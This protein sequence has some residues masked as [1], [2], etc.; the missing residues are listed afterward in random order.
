[1]DQTLH[2]GKTDRKRGRTPGE[3]AFDRCFLPVAALFV[4]HITTFLTAWGLYPHPYKLASIPVSSWELWTS[5]SIGVLLAVL[6]FRALASLVKGW[7]D[8]SS[9]VLRFSASVLLF[10]FALAVFGFLTAPF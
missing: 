3:Q 8:P 1:M 2:A 10:P 5:F 4:F 6:W 9:R 7:R